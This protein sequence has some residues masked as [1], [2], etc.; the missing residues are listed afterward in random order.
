VIGRALALGLD[1]QR[2]LRVVLSVPGREGVEELEPIARG[3][4]PDL[5]RIGI[6]RRS[7]E[8]DLVLDE[9]SGGHVGSRLGGT[10]PE[11]GAPGGL[12]LVLGRVDREPAGEPVGH[13]D[14]R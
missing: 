5:H 2:K 12:D 7:L 8:P 6:V 11:R 10:E 13:R 1:Q 9:A 4:H 14:L 3:C